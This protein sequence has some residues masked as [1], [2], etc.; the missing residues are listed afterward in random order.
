MMLYGSL[1]LVLPTAHLDS[2]GQ[3]GQALDLASALLHRNPNELTRVQGKVTLSMD[4]PQFPEQDIQRE[5][6]KGTDECRVP[7]LA[8]QYSPKRDGPKRSRRQSSLDKLVMQ[9]ADGQNREDWKGK[10]D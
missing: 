3:R 5:R 6:A 4:L 2:L 1:L 9:W 8:C 7:K 10:A